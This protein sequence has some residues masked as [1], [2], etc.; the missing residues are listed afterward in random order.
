[1]GGTT[2]EPT[3]QSTRSIRS[4]GPP[5]CG[6]NRLNPSP[7]MMITCAPGPC[8]CAFLYVPTG[9]CDTWA[10]CVLSAS[11]NITLAPPA[12]R[13]FHV[14]VVNVSMSGMKFVSHTFTR[15]ELPVNIVPSPWNCRCAAMR[16]SN[17]NE[18]LKMKSSLWK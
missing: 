11:S 14:N 8:R 18:L 13:S 7:E 9:N 15:P 12:P 10:A 6:H 3:F 5:S 17:T 2:I 1:M 4:R 16:S